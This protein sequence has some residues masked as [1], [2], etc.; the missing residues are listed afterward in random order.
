M[1]ETLLILHFIGLALGVGT[2]FA[3]LTLGFAAASLEPAERGKFMLRASLLSKNGS[4]GL[5]LLIL[6]GLGILFYRGVGN[7]M[8]WGGGAFHAKLTLVLVLCGLVGYMQVTLKKARQGGGP[9]LMAKLRML[10]RV[11]LAVSVL[12]VI[13]AVVAF[14]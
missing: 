2:S 3:M 6:S 8:Q 12:I 10:G 7:V 5:A 1:Y 9:E 4:I 13:L 14:K 11:G